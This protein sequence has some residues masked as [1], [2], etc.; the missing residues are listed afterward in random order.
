MTHPSGVRHVVTSVFVPGS[1]TREMGTFVPNGASR[2]L[3]ASRS[4][5]VPKMLGASKRGTQSQSIDPST[6][7]SAPVW[8]SDRNAYESIGGNGEGI[9]ALWPLPG[10]MMRSRA[11]ASGRS[12]R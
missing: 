5:R 6:A 9:A 7:M 1:Y 11:R 8:Q 12:L 2:K 3:P 10:V 4:S